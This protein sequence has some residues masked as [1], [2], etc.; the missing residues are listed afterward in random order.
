MDLVLIGVNHRTADAAARAAMALDAEGRQRILARIRAEGVLREAAILST[1]NRTEFYGVADD[2]DEGRSYLQTLVAGY[3]Q[4]RIDAGTCGFVMDTAGAALHLHRVAA[5]LDS[6]M[7]GEPQIM[8]QVREAHAAARNAGSL[9]AMLDRLWNGA[10]H[11]GKRAR[12]ETGIT[13]GAVSVASAA[14]ALAERVFGSLAGRDVLIVGAGATGRL[15]ARHFAE[16]DVRS[17]I[18]ANR[19]IGRAGQ[20]AAECR[21]R[22]IGL[23]GV[24]GALMT[25]DVVVSA[26]S[27]PGL[28]ITADMIAASAGARPDSPL[29]LVDIA[30]PPDIDPGAGRYENVYLYPIDALQTM[31]DQNL[32]KRQREVPRAEAIVH[33]ECDRFLAWARGRGA[34]PVVRELREHFER[35]RADEVSRS[36]GHFS[37]AD[38]EHV[39][40]LTRS[41]V[42]RLL[43]IPTAR[44]KT[45][46]PASQGG[47]MSLAAVRNVFALQE[48]GHNGESDHGC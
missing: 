20:V 26:T 13:A 5:G 9:G 33:D 44:L 29:L 43:H 40:R 24:A 2:G 4:V 25:C 30:M 17:I 48:P 39:D 38:R 42:N 14:V 27:A 41:I 32:S 1:C 19:S 15:A 7:L 10:L 6:M 28:V 31:V 22:A 8:G 12:A 3:S 36:L 11:A 37:D 45:L 16:R 21:G 46:D 47:A 18:V 23:D 34:A 35:V